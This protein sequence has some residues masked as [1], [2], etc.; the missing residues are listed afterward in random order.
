MGKKSKR[1]R[2]P[3]KKQARSSNSK[4]RV[5]IILAIILVA[6]GSYFFYFKDNRNPY[7]YRSDNTPVDVDALKGGEMRTTLSPVAFV[8]NVARAYDVARENRELLDSMYCYCN[9]KKHFGH[10]SLLTC[11]VDNHAVNCDI[12]Q[13]QAFYAVSRF[14]AGDNIAQVRF[15]VDKKFWRPLR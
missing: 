14:E 1:K 8:G 2:T 10:K 9:C 7:A 12:C 5:I 13:D 3:R 4:K 6:A 15:A 11:F